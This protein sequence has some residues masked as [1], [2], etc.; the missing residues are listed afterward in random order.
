MASRADLPDVTTTVPEVYGPHVHN[1]DCDE[2]M[3]GVGATTRGFTNMPSQIGSTTQKRDIMMVAHAMP[4]TPENVAQ[5]AF[6]AWRHARLHMVG[7]A[8]VCEVDA[9]FLECMARVATRDSDARE[10]PQVVHD[11]DVT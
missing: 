6:G 7:T 8:F 9:E 11:G 4:D 3:S 1:H 5:N 10:M 2:Y